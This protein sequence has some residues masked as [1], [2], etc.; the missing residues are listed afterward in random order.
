MDHWP[1]PVHNHNHYELIFISEGSGI[2][3]L[4]NTAG[5]Y[6]GGSIFFLA[7]EDTH[8][9]NIKSTT[10]F[11]VLKFHPSVLNGGINKSDSDYW[12]HL[13]VFLAREWNYIQGPN[14]ESEIFRA[15]KSIV[16]VIIFHWKDHTEKVTEIHCHL[17]RSLLLIMDQYIREVK[18]Y[19]SASHG[20]VLI[21]RI[22]NHIH[23]HINFPDKLTAKYLANAFGMSES[24]LRSF[25]KNKMEISLAAYCNDL[26]TEMIKSRIINSE[27]TF[28]QI[29]LEFGFT[30]A[31][32]FHKFFTRHTKSSPSEFRASSRLTK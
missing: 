15:I 16:Q 26:K 9:F 3:T 30:D 23:N 12:E 2:H 11:S 29:A 31:S 21:E 4:N 5:N 20:Y 17:L 7:P 19:H 10:Q 1:F 22:Q 6:Q 28:S 32:H 25:F 8:D 27:Q 13:L 18:D 24:G 14:I